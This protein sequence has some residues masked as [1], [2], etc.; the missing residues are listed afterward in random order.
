MRSAVALGGHRGMEFS[1]YIVPRSSGQRAGGM[2]Q[3]IVSLVGGGARGLKCFR[4]ATSPFRAMNPYSDMG[5]GYAFTFHK[6]NLVYLHV[7]SEP[8]F[9]KQH[10]EPNLSSER[11]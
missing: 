10:P 3:R 4:A 6:M 8:V 2:L 9:E 11:V 1:G 5:S 7:D